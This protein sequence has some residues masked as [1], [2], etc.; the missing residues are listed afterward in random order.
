MISEALTPF[1]ALF[2]Y[3]EV[4][5]KET[6]EEVII[7]LSSSSYKSI[8]VESF[9]EV[10]D[11]LEPR[12]TLEISYIIG[13]GTPLNFSSGGNAEVFIKH[14]DRLNQ[15]REQEEISIEIK[16]TKEVVNGLL[17]VYSYAELILFLEGLSIQ[18]LFFEFNRLLKSNPFLI[19]ENQS[20]GPTIKTRSIWFTN[21]GFLG[22]PEIIDRAT[23]LNKAK[24][25]C[26]YN[27]LADFVVLPVDFMLIVKDCNKLTDLFSRLTISA[28][29]MF[30]YDISVLA[31]SKLNYKLNGYKSIT[32]DADLTKLKADPE[33]Q[34]Y[35]IYDWVYESG[36]F[37]DKIGLARNIISLHLDNNNS[38]E[39]KG[40][41]FQSIQSSYKVY[42]KQNIKQYIEIRNK[43]SDQLLSF[44]DRAN[45]IIETFAGGFQKSALALITFYT[46]AIALKILNKD[47]LIEVFTLDAS[48][49]ST[50]FI[51]CSAGYYIII[52]K[53]EVNAQRNRFENNYKD[54]KKRYTDLLDEQ[55]IER[56]LNND[57]EFRSDLKFMID[58]GK[59]YSGLW[60]Y[61]LVVLLSTTWLLYFIYN[62]E[63][64]SKIADWFKMIVCSVV[65]YFS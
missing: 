58:K 45:R 25:A 63:L 53:W 28:A 46:S 16:V 40:D 31:G 49:L 29:V 24:T 21:K 43:I 8:G 62:V 60:F 27:F 7:K 14:I 56:I 52:S 35:K 55:D 64:L 18:S 65:G 34:Y 51:L 44:H 38:I 48:V 22:I 6:F 15:I 37:I 1:A 20:A 26:H 36:N 3:D 39:L 41:P 5:V 4:L 13:E 23:V 32:G 10:V 12:D 50:S 47:K 54:I 11:L 33:S 57:N 19:F 9:N 30:L 17:S 61:F 59:F 2:H 42:E